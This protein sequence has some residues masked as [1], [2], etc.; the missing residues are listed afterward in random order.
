MHTRHL[1]RLRRRFE[2]IRL[3]D[4]IPEMLF[5]NSHDGTTAY[6]MLIL[7]CHQWH[8][9]TRNAAYLQSTGARGAMV[10]VS[11]VLRVLVRLL[12]EWLEVS[13]PSMQAA[14]ER[15]AQLAQLRRLA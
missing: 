9:S 12:I 7:I 13:L 5:L 1:I 11:D 15:L 8:E 3:R 10:T 6:L 2:I 14:R 4:A